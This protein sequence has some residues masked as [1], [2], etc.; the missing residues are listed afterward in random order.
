[1]D[2]NNFYPRDDR[3]SLVNYDTSLLTHNTGRGDNSSPLSD[4]RVAKKQN[5]CK[6]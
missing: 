6:V 3:N 2:D 1:M 4:I 5:K